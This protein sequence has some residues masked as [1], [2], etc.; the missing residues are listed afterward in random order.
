MTEY[1]S[2]KEA[3]R[4]WG[5][6]QTTVAKWCREGLLKNGTAPCE[7]DKPGSPWRIR[8]DAIPPNEQH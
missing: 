3:A 1:M 6:T 8:K 4:R 7:Q 2:S 5:V